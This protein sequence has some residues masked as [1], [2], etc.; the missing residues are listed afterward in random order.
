MSGIRVGSWR[1]PPVEAP[2][3]RR[4][5]I[6]FAVLFSSC[7]FAQFSQTSNSQPNQVQDVHRGS[8]VD[9]AQLNAMSEQQLEGLGDEM[10]GNKEMLQAV[11]CYEAALRKTP[12]SAVLYNKMGMAYIAIRD[13]PKARKALEKAIKLDKKYP[14]AYNNLGAVWYAEAF[15]NSKKKATDK[16]RK[17]AKYYNKAI[18]LNDL[19]ASFHSNL[20]TAYLDLQEYDRGIA[21]YRKAYSLDPGIFERNSRTGIAARLSSPEDLAQYNYFMARLFASNGETDKALLYLAHAMEN[22]YKGINKVYEDTE[23]AKLRTDQRFTELMAKR[24][25]GITQ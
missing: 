18:G 20:G 24:P 16:I 4:I 1:D 12:R 7:A 14:E 13:Y 19:F 23:F 15:T 5:A 2:M 21:E 9:P 17:A 3:V 11:D 8:I 25:S 22:G 6:V 10:R